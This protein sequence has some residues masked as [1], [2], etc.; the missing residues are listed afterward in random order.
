MLTFLILQRALRE[1]NIVF[2]NYTI[3]FQ[4][5][6]TNRIVIKR[7]ILYNKFGFYVNG[8]NFFTKF[9]KEQNTLTIYD[10]SKQAGVSI[11]TVSRV[12]NGSANVK[13]RGFYRFFYHQ[14]PIFRSAY[15]VDDK[16]EYF[17]LTARSAH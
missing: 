15:R 9:E 2:T 10:I 8:Y 11:A 7:L 13:P 14:R 4:T 17:C 5:F 1:V 12:L 3:F 6:F 16:V